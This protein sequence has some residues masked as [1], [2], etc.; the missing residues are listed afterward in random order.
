MCFASLTKTN[1]GKILFV[2]CANSEGRARINLTLRVSDDDC[3]S[4]KDDIILDPI[5]GYADIACVGE[6][7]AY[8]FYERTVDKGGKGVIEQLILCQIN[9]AD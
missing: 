9:L 3:K 8:C 2:N 5:G 7:T 1:G 6:D 4:W